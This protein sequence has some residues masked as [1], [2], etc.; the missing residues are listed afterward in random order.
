MCAGLGDRAEAATLAGRK[1][2]LL[3]AAKR[4]LGSAAASANAHL[5]GAV[6]AKHSDLGP[7]VDAERQALQVCLQRL[8]GSCRAGLQAALDS[9]ETTAVH[10]ALVQSAWFEP[11][12]GELRAVVRARAAELASN[13]AKFHRETPSQQTGIYRHA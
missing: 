10:E 12:L 4:E 5:I 11:G 6:L 2:V 8:E 1:A 9:A 3:Q 13:G 7:E